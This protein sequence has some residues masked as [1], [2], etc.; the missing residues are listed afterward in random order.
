MLAADLA[1]EPISLV[2]R[3]NDSAAG[4]QVGALQLREIETKRFRVL[5]R[6]APHEVARNRREHEVADVGGGS[7]ERNGNRDARIG[8]EAQAD[9]LAGGDSRIAAAAVALVGKL[10]M[11]SLRDDLEHVLA[12][13]EAQDWSVFEAASWALAASRMPAEKRRELWQEPLPAVELADRLRVLPLFAFTSVDEL[14][15]IGA[16]VRAPAIGTG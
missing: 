13:R 3:A 8:I 5:P 7:V 16:V 10:G 9:A 11:W 4:A 1:D 12:H 2:T 15:R 14:F 6:H